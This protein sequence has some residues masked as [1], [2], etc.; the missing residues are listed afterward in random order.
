MPFRPQRMN[1][2]A[3]REPED[4]LLLNDIQMAQVI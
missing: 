2:L 4:P 3:V 1:F